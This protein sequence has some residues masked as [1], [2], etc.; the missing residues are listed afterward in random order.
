[1]AMKESGG[2]RNGSP[3]CWET[4]DRLRHW[5]EAGLKLCN[6]W[7]LDLFPKYGRARII[8]LRKND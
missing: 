8:N 2:L 3:R 5:D 7:L 1:M 4:S 6:D